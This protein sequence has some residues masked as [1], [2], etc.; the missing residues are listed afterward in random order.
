VAFGPRRPLTI[1][2][3]LAVPLLFATAVLGL[4]G[5]GGVL[6]DASWRVTLSA[7]LFGPAAAVTAVLAFGVEWK[8][9]RCRICLGFGYPALVFSCGLVFN[10]VSIPA[11][12]AMVTGIPAVI[13]LGVVIARERN[14]VAPIA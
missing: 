9:Q 13:I 6:L 14:K 12:V 1:P 3:W 7:A 8:R 10:D 11:P 2:A 5:L 4:T